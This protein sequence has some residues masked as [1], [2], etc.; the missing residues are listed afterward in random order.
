MLSM[1]IVILTLAQCGPAG[2][3][4]RPQP[5]PQAASIVMPIPQPIP[6]PAVESAPYAEIEVNP[7]WGWYFVSHENLVFPVWGYHVDQRTVRWSPSLPANAAV[8]AHARLTR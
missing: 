3:P 1:M 2:C 7:D 5:I 6:Q 4:F 8:L